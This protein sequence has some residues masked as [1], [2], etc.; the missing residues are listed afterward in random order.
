MDKKQP[1]YPMNE[2]GRPSGVS[3][4]SPKELDLMREAGQIVGRTLQTLRMSVEPGMETRE[5][6]AIAERDIVSMGGKPA[7]K[8]YR[9]FPATLCVS[10]NHQIVHGIPGGLV[11][12]EGDMVSLDL[13]A[14]VGG[15]Y[16]DSAITV[17]VG[18]VP[19]EE[20]RLLEVCEAS[21]WAGIEQAKPGAR[22]GDVSAAIQGE[23]ERRGTY[24][25]VREYGGHGI[26]RALHEEPFLPNFGQ[27]NRGLLLRPGMV[28]A[29]EPMVNIGGD[30]TK[31]MGDKRTVVTAD[32]TRSAHFEHTVA[33]TE[34][35]P[36]VLTAVDST[37]KA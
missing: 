18:E 24:G 22:L 9:G 13:G 10:V 2:L 36:E 23:V 35:G 3:I 28:I 25:L 21:L 32:G 26:G 15:M 30:E 14:I 31:V 27:P 37:P 11:V 5:L 8:G 4:K 1:T 7:F 20:Q 19:E 16:G 34:D 17:V 29:I 33:I 6:D 12:Q